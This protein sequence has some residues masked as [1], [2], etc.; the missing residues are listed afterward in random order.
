MNFVAFETSSDTLSVAVSRGDVTTSEEIADAGQK[1]SELT[2]PLMHRLL[3][4]ASLT[5]A[6][7]DA[8]VFGQGPGSFTGVR[9]ACGLAQGLAFG[10]GKPV[11]ALPSTLVLAEQACANVDVNK[12][13][14]PST[15]D[16]A[17]IIVAIDARMGEIY[18]AAYQRDDSTDSGFI[19]VVAPLLTKPNNL[20]ELA[21]R[22]CAIGSAFADT[23][24]HDALIGKMAG[25]IHAVV[26]PAL[27]QAFFL[28]TLARRLYARLGDACTIHARDAAPIYLRNK[29]AM[30]IEE[31]R[32]FHAAKSRQPAAA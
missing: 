12:Y 5:L 15:T 20:P 19:E 27:P 28:L 14:N 30:T 29:V 26:T 4:E 8:V 3:A 32:Q 24:L 2:L 22:W 31:R 11:I 16:Q 25:G 23:A 9:I 7:I 21:G 6:D 1:N 17:N 18:F 13:V 10:L